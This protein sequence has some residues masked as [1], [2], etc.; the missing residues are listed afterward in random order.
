MLDLFSTERIIMVSVN[1]L[2]H[3]L[4]LQLFIY[5]APHNGDTAPK[6]G[7]F[8]LLLNCRQFHG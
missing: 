1:I 7:T 6:I 8:E 3:V 5:T 4:Q 2:V